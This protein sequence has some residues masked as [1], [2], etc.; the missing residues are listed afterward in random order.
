MPPATHTCPPGSASTDARLVFCARKEGMATERQRRSFQRTRPLAVGLPGPPS[1]T[2]QM[3]LAETALAS[4]TP[5][6]PAGPG[7][8]MARQVLPLKW[9]AYEWTLVET[10]SNPNAQA[11]CIPTARPM[12]SPRP[13]LPPGNVGTR[14]VVQDE[15]LKRSQLPLKSNA[16]MLLSDVPATEL[17]T[18]TFART[19]AGTA[20]FRQ[21]VPFQCTT[22]SPVLAPVGPTAHASP[23]PI[24]VTA[25][26]WT[27]SLFGAMV[28][29]TCQPVAAEAGTG[30]PSAMTAS[31][32]TARITVVLPMRDIISRPIARSRMCH[33]CGSIE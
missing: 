22:M 1:T 6:W 12:A 28:A 13:L 3:S 10:L 31:P 23:L 29:N 9:A 33:L 32:L 8:D 18:L 30:L 2:A 19:P 17:R 24:A 14:P 20:A 7:S 21:W 15:P 26:S 25:L 27:S 16:Q 4:K 11:S 5:N